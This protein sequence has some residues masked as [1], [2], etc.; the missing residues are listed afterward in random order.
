MSTTAPDAHRAYVERFA[1]ALTEMGMQRMSARVLALFVCTDS[2]TLTGTDI[3]EQLAVSPA[4]VSGA[5]RILQQAG[6]V[7][8]TPAPGSRRDHYRLSGDAW[9]DAGVAKRESLDGLAKL[10]ADGLDVVAADGPAADRLGEM[11]DFYRFLAEEI[12]LLMQRW[13]ARRG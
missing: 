4:A 10:A 11:R 12:P 3:A 13:R 7:Q 2:P 1:M 5:I 9:T 8:R 6:L